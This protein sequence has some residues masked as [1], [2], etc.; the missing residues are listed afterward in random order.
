MSALG[1]KAH[2]SQY[3]RDVVGASGG[4]DPE[5]LNLVRP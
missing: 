2:I 3:N 4:T 1:S 5:T